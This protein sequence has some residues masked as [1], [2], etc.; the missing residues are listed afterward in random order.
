LLF[1]KERKGTGKRGGD[2]RDVRDVRKKN[3]N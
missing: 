1:S 2:I 3:S